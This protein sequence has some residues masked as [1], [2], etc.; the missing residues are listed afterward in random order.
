MGSHLAIAAMEPFLDDPFLNRVR[1]AYR[2]AIEAG[3]PASS[4]MWRDIDARRGDVDAALLA[5]DNFALRAI[6][7]NPAKTDL[8]FGV[9]NL[10]RSI[11]GASDRRPF[12]ELAMTSHR[13]V[14]ARYQ[15]QQLRQALA[16]IQGMSVIEIGPGVGHCA[17]FSYLAGVTDYTTIDLPLGMVAQA[18]FLAEALGPDKIWMDG[19]A[20]PSGKQ[21][22]LCSVAHLPDRHFDVVLNVDSM[23]EMSLRAALDYASW[24]NQQ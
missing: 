9:D 17:F 12:L 5:D 11:T 23:T 20:N 4:R 7:A 19:D 14:L 3:V 24:I 6:F 8:Y 15:A 13:A 22:K 21:L 1:R 18:R 10:C 2:L 16:A